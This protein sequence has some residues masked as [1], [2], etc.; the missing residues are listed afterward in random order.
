MIRMPI[1]SLLSSVFIQPVRVL[2]FSLSQW[3]LLIR[4]ARKANVLGTLAT[5]F[6]QFDIDDSVPDQPRRHLVS[7]QIYTDRFRI[8]LSS[9]ISCIAKALENLT[10]PIVF[11]KG[12]AYHLASDEAG[13]SRI[14][15]DIDIL[16]P[17]VNL[18]EVE[19]AL[20][21]G[22]WMTT[23][24]DSYDQK[25]Y[26]QW[27]H[28]IPP[29]RH[30]KRQTTIDVHHNILPKTC[31][32]C[33]DA[34]RLL[35]RI[36]RVGDGNAWVLAPEDRI[37]HSAAHLF[38]EGELEHGFRD[39]SDLDSLLKQYST[40]DKFWDEL[41]LRA[42]ELNQRIPL[43]YALRYS[44][45]ILQTPVPQEV[46]IESESFFRGDIRRHFMDFLFLRAL[47]P[48]HPSCSDR[49]TGLARWLLYIR[50][51]WLKMPL[52][53]LVPHLLRKSWMRLIG[54]EKH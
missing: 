9:E 10:I 1:E 7:A 39:L 8:S 45:T 12:A 50:S 38:H 43:Y 34:E 11:L 3:D 48:D 46:L 40:Q 25:Y 26:R 17:E 53:L 15:S 23:T 54:K 35:S 20:I 16:V 52:Y 49:W 5:L 24:F 37:L 30:L 6:E 31:E 29:M 18:P 4:Q 41:L 42:D 36:V 44:H 2:E 13:K 32:F 51:H 21:K 27:M 28:E 22:G 47:M 14:F 19:R 33:P